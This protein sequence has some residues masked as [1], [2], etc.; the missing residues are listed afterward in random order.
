[1]AEAGDG[2]IVRR[3]I[4]FIWR[5]I[6]VPDLA[7]SARAIQIADLA[8]YDR[9]HDTSWARKWKIVTAEDSSCAALSLVALMPS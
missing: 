6:R 8:W 7:Q 5:S 2:K 3:R 1:M 4:L 9:L